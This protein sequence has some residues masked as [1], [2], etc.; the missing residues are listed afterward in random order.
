[1][2]QIAITS[3]LFSA[4]LFISG[5][6]PKTVYVNVPVKCNIPHIDTPSIYNVKYEDPLEASKQCAK[7]YFIMKEYAEQL[8]AA[9]DVCR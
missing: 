3:L 8:N 7:N 2:R 1:M 5:C 6:T 4:L 9:S